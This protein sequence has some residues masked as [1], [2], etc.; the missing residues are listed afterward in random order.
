MGGGKDSEPDVRAASVA[1]LAE[2]TEGRTKA[3]PFCAETIKV[4]AVK[5]KHCGGALNDPSHAYRALQAALDALDAAPDPS[6]VASSDPAAVAAYAAYDRSDEDGTDGPLYLVYS[7][8][9]D[10]AYNTSEA[11][12]ARLE[13]ALAAARAAV[14]ESESEEADLAPF[15]ADIGAHKALPPGY[16]AKVQ[17]P[18]LAAPSHATKRCPYCAEDVR[19]EAIKCKHCGSS[20]TTAKNPYTAGGDSRGFITAGGSVALM[21]CPDCKAGVSASARTCP[22]CGF[23]IHVPK[24]GMFG[25][26]FKWSFIA[27]NALMVYWLVAGMNAASNVKAP[28]GAQQAGRALGT[29]LGASMIVGIWVAGSIILGLFVLFTRPK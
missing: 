22:K 8:A 16:A 23:V 24:R 19:V 5:C 20:L 1:A 27:W 26:L 10:A 11:T 12:R 6:A 4:Q 2:P 21:A 15:A 28:T 7:A 13:S 3:C 14:A 29:A 18:A 9:Y 17:A 25:K